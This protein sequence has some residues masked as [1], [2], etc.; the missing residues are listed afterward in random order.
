MKLF[1]KIFPAFEK[2]D[3]RHTLT[4][5]QKFKRVLLGILFLLVWFGIFIV[6]PVLL[7]G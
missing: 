1:Y 5:D 3:D 2:F 6:L 4:Q 7:I